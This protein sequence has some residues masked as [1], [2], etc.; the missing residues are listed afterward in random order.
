MKDITKYVGLDVSK[1]K[2]AVAIAEEG[3]EA[4]RFWGTI[5]NAPEA[6][7]KLMNQLGKPGQLKVCYEAGP[8]GYGLYRQLL[9]IGI[10]C[11][12][13][14]PS[15]IPKKPG[16]RVKTDR[17]D[18][19]RLA[20]LFRAGEL[21]SIYVPSEEDEALRDLVRAR[22]DAKEDH[23]RARHRL[24]K[25]LLRYDINPP[26]GIR[27]WTAK[28]RA[29]LN[30]LDF[31]QDTLRTVFREYLHHLDEIEQRINRLEAE[32]H[33]QATQSVK[34]PVIQALQTLRGV[35][36][37]TATSLVAEIGSFSRFAEAPLLMGYTGL[38]PSEY[39]SGE[40]RRQG[41]ITKSG[42]RHVRRL[43]IEAAWSYR[44]KPALKGEIRKRQKGQPAQIQAIA[45]K[46]QERLHRK[47]YRLVGRGKP[48]G[49]AIAAIA[50]ELA[51]FV[52]AV[53]CEIEKVS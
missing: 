41:K 23:L 16:E 51:G 46:A 24:T 40:T 35:A 15:L 9:S 5:H 12:V 48:S 49:K 17:R 7:K 34:A 33:T 45:W 11:T 27:K 1:E 53:A 26:K 47:Y 52:W 3:R 29:W 31:K 20:Q 18:A 13:V 2:I 28:Y 38:V 19:I 39:S 21:T 32:I 36:E 37:I 44:Y 25:F 8:T 6:I 30:S 10:E 43:L 14:A 4:P 50:R 22:E 42:N